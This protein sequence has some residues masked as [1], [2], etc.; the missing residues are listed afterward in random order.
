MSPELIKEVLSQNHTHI[1]FDFKKSNIF[2][3]GLI[4]LKTLLFL[5]PKYINE[6]NSNE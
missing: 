2:S 4:I 1:N 5:H 3:I 6:I